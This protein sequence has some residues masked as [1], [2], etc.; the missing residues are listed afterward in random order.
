MDTQVLIGLDFFVIVNSTFV[1]PL[2]VLR[3]LR[4]ESPPVFFTVAVGLGFKCL[5]RP[6]ILTHFDTFR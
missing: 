3:V 2:R 1:I 4:V 5:S 6:D